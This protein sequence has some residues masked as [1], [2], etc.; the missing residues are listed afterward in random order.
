MPWCLVGIFLRTKPR[1]LLAFVVRFWICV[2]QLR[3]WLISSPKYL[4][5]STASR[6]WPCRTYCCLIGV[7]ARV[8]SSTWHLRGLNYISQSFPLISSLWR[9]CWRVWQSAL[10][11]IVNYTA[12]SSEYSLTS[13]WMFSGRSLIYKRNKIGPKTE[14]WGTPD[15]TGISDDFS[16]SKATHCVRPSK[17]A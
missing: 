1:V 17:K 7:R 9:S 4:A 13:E 14:P 15:M 12:V 5:W 3:S 11:F 16:P 8:I 2:F 6:T 10:L